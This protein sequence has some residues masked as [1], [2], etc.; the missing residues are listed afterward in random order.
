[1]PAPDAEHFLRVPVRGRDDGAAGGKAEGECSRGDLLAR[2]VR[3]HEHVGCR[4]QVRDLLDR[5][6]PLVEL[7][8]ILEAKVEH[9][10]LERPS[11]PL[12]LA[13]CDV[14]MRS[15]GDHVQHLRV[16]LH[17]RGQRFDDRLEPF[18]GRDQPERRE[19]E[20]VFRPAGHL[21]GRGRLAQGA[22]DEVLAGASL[23]HRRGAVGHDPNL[24]GRAGT[25]LDEETP[26]RVRH[27][28]HELGLAAEGREHLAPGEASAPTAPYG[29]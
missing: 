20:P 17:D 13:A 29:A 15:P 1:M 9:R 18:P 12:A 19:Q 24:V 27:H 26:R 21:V 8:V 14:G 10:L 28:D 7:D 3:S 25:S 16:A 23:E 6:E 5:E 22:L 11:I 4:E 2:P